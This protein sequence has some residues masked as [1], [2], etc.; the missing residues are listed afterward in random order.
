[1]DYIPFIEELDHWLVFQKPQRPPPEASH[2]N[3]CPAAQRLAQLLREHHPSMADVT[4]V[5]LQCEAC[6]LDASCTPGRI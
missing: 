6:E 4:T 5:Q 3:D 2:A 1:M